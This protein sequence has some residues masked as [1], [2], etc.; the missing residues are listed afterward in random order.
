MGLVH[1]DVGR[2]A[3]VYIF[4]DEISRG[5]RL[6]RSRGNPDL[7]VVFDVGTSNPEQELTPAQTSSESHYY[8]TSITP[9]TD[10]IL[11]LFPQSKY[12]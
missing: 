2:F 10:Y 11:V 3:C 9:Y 5:N 12:T 6:S 1:F 4:V 8:S 7:P